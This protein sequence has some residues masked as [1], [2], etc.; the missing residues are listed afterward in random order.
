M[1]APCEPWELND[2]CTRGLDPVTVPL[3]AY[4]VGVATELLWRG[5]AGIYGLC[6]VTA[7]PCGRRCS[8]NAGF[9]YWPVLTGAGEWINITCGCA[10]QACG[11]CSVSDIPL[12]GPVDS[13]VEVLIDG[14]VV[15]PAAYRLDNGYRLTKVSGDPWPMCQDLSK[16]GT[17][18]GTFQIRYMRGVPVPVAGQYALAALAAELKLACLD[19]D[20]RLPARVREISR[21]G[22]T[23]QLVND[24]DFLKSGLYGLPEVDMWL[25]S[26]NPNGQRSQSAV[27]SPDLQPRM[28]YPG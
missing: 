5:T 1:G 13:I 9:T 23:M 6:E 26:V 15:A 2:A 18:V 24:V 22:V 27:W 14:V 4:V 12:E 20:C 25:M 3:D 28:R 7:R 16:P 17:E 10:D 21:Q 19:E 11:C 8:D